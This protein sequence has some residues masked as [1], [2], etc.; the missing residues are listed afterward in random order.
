MPALRDLR[1]H[2]RF[3]AFVQLPQLLFR[4]LPVSHLPFEIVGVVL[5]CGLG[6]ALLGNVGMDA[7]PFLDLTAAIEDRHGADRKGAVLAVMA[8]HAMLVDIGR[9][10]GNGVLPGDDG[11]CAII[12][13]HGIRPAIALVVGKALA[14]KACP[15]GLRADHPAVRTIGPEDTVDRIDGRPEALVAAGKILA[16]LCQIRNRPDLLGIFKNGT[17]HAVDPALLAVDRRIEEIENHV[18][19]RAIA[20]QRHRLVAEGLH[21]AAKTGS[22]NA[23]VPVPYLRPD[24]RNRAAEGSRVV[25]AGDID[26]AVIVD[27]HMIGTPHE[28]LRDG[29]IDHGIDLDAQVLRPLVDRP[30]GRCRPI[31]LANTVAGFAST[32]WPLDGHGLLRHL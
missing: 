26:I 5:K 4:P 20:A 25:I 9:L 24:A 19:R 23:A 12:G 30:K 29:R 28:N 14:G 17:E 18:F 27:H 8:T 22:Q 16:A 7:N 32:N 15:A 11:G 13:V 21:F 6:R 3:E 10:G 2:P 1:F 31:E